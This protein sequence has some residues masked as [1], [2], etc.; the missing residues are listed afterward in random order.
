MNTCNYAIP[1]LDV[2]RDS[3]DPDISYM[4][5]PF[6][7]MDSPPCD[8]VHEVVDFADQVLEGM[9]FLHEHGVAHRD[10]PRKNIM[11]DAREMSPEGFHPV[12]EGRARYL[13][14]SRDVPAPH[15]K[16]SI[17]GLPRGD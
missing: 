17:F 8:V 5:M 15:S 1:I 7:L 12:R 10:C 14:R 11:M 3:V 9:V 4:G 13:P 2:I 16:V 6:R